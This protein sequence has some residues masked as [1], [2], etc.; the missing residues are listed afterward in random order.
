[1]KTKIMSSV[2]LSGIDQEIQKRDSLFFGYKKLNLLLLLF[3][4]QQAAFS[5]QVIENQCFK[6]VSGGVFH[7]M[8]IK[9]DGTLWGWGDNEYGQLGDGTQTYKLVPTQVGIS[10]NWNKISAGQQY[11]MAIKTD[12]TLWGWGSNNYTLG[13]GTAFLRIVPT[14]I[15]TDTNWSEVSAGSY[16]T[17]A[18]KTDGTLWAWGSNDNSELFGNIVANFITV[19]TQ[20]GTDT[21][22]SKIDM[23]DRHLLAL[24]TNGTLWSWGIDYY[25]EIGIGLSTPTVV[26]FPTQ[27]GIGNNWI[28]ISAGVNQSLATK[29]DGTLWAWGFNEYGQLGDGTVINKNIPIQIESDTNWTKVSAGTSHSLGQKTDGTLWAWGYN[30]RGQ[31]GDGTQTNRNSLTQVGTAN[32]WNVSNAG[33]FHTLAIKQDGTLAAVGWNNYGQLGD[34]TGANRTTLFEIGCPTLLVKDF[35]KTGNTIVYPNPFSTILNLNTESTIDEI[36]IYNTLGQIIIVKKGSLNQLD[37]SSFKQG[38][39]FVK[40]KSNNQEQIIKAYKN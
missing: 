37:V 38:A 30:N 20:I 39:Y 9:Q 8:A 29:T 34:G 10:T 1:M 32:N 19:P 31:L 13:D 11:T 36:T 12:G 3:F 18:I 7:S 35:N 23:G 17:L 28:S 6:A 5:Q 22:W 33:A 2:R 14:Q 25:G 21:N 26:K 4:V 27:I 24:K 16:K 15:G 40:I